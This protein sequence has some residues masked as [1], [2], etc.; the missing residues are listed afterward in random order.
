MFDYLTSLLGDLNIIAYFI[1]PVPALLFVSIFTLFAVLAERKISAYMQDRY[2]PNRTGKGI[3]QTVADMA[4]LIQKEFISPS[5]ADRW[6]FELAPFIVF[7]S[8]FMGYAVIPFAT[9]YVGTDL[10]LGLF[11]FFAI[12]SLSVIGILIAGW[13]SHNKYTLIGAMR[14]AAQIVSYEIPA[15][16][17][18]LTVVMFAG[19]LSMQSI[20]VAQSGG[21]HNWYVFGGPGDVSRILM[22][23][24]MAASCL[25][26][27]IAT[28]AETNR[29]PFDIP[30]GESEIVAGFNLEYS[31]MKFA[32]FFFAEYS[33][34]FAV[35]AVLSTLFLGGWQSPFGNLIPVLNTPLFQI[36]WF[37]LKGLLIVYVQMWLRW[38]LPRLRVDQLMTMCWKYLIPIT[39]IIVLIVGFYLVI[40]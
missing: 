4:K 10:N 29:T 2:G 13:A 31:G 23:P 19:T 26:F 6:L 27:F 22:I 37:L 28:L 5:H 39:L 14:S 16:L 17:S 25:I 35:A 40:R 15:V 3:L 11:Y 9:V 21:I 20:V 33:Q 36:F 8:V 1:V 18:A 24:F 38:T 30:E 7:A 32:F 34:M 12:T